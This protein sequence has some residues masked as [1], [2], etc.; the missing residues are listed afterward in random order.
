[1]SNIIGVR[2]V[3]VSDG[4]FELVPIKYPDRQVVSPSGSAFR[5]IFCRKF[6]DRNSATYVH[7]KDINMYER[8]QS[9]TKQCDVVSLMARAK[10]DPSVLQQ[11]A[12]FYGDFSANGDLRDMLHA[13]GDLKGVFENF[14]EE[15]KKK[16]G[17]SF[18]TFISGLADGSFNNETNEQEMTG[19]TIDQSEVET[20][21]Q[22]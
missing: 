21:E 7:T 4:S 18:E 19:D 6:N 10:I 3:S 20:Y 14:N 15:E 8:I 5:S 16:F 22:K 1:M 11:K 17:G 2:L 13:Y 9:Y 12:G